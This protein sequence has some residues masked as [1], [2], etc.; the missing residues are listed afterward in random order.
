MFYSWTDIEKLGYENID[1]F[2]YEITR[3][4]DYEKVIVTPEGIEIIRKQHS[5]DF[6]PAPSVRKKIAQCKV[7]PNLGM[8]QTETDFNSFCKK[9]KI[10]KED[11]IRVSYEDGRIFLVYNKEL[12]DED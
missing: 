5:S 11:I 2:T 7:F 3:Q 1:D 9:N 6:K 10:Q 8:E 4:Q 12:T